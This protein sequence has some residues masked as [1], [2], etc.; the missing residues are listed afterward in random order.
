M[1]VQLQILFKKSVETGEVPEDWRRAKVV[2]IYKK[3]T[4]GEAGNYRPVSLTSVPCKLL[5]GSIKDELMR[6]LLENNLIRSSQHCFMAGKSYTT[7]LVEFM[8]MATKVV[9]E[10]DAAYIFYLDFAKAFDKVP[11]ERLLVKLQSKGD[12]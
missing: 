4:K 5:E 7:N 1:T 3:G 11:H 8:D 6:N 9:D 2:P 10:G 12:R